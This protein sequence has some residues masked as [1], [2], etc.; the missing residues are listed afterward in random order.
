MPFCTGATR[1]ATN[2]AAD[3]A[4]RS[5]GVCT[6]C[7][8][9][10]NTI[11]TATETNTARTDAAAT[12]ADVACIITAARLTNPIID[13]HAP[14]THQAFAADAVVAATNNTADFT[15][16]SI[17]TDVCAYRA[18]YALI[19]AVT[20]LI[21]ATATGVA[22]TIAHIAARTR[23][24]ATVWDAKARGARIARITVATRLTTY[25]AT[26]LA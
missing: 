12:I 4:R 3:R 8:F 23:R 18:I 15:T 9:N 10:A 24:H 6:R 17:A 1:F 13:A 2:N 25:L 19:A 14:A 26:L 7:V 5:A 20:H 16:L 11:A 21:V 22:A